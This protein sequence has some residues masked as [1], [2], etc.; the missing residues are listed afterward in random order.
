MRVVVLLRCT[1]PV[2]LDKEFGRESTPHNSVFDG[3]EVNDYIS[4]QQS[5]RLT[6][7]AQHCCCSPIGAF[8]GTAS[9]KQSG[10][11]HAETW[12]SSLYSRPEASRNKSI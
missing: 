10:G 2:W 7:E 3:M 11:L 8:E 4:L 5:T 6:R 12:R 9:V 1:H